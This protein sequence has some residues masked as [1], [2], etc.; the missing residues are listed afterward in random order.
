MPGIKIWSIPENRDV[1]VSVR[2]GVVSSLSDDVLLE[3]EDNACPCRLLLHK[4]FCVHNG[5]LHGRG[6]SFD[7]VGV[8][9]EADMCSV[10]QDDPLL[11][12]V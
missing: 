6:T 12:R 7:S 10:L 9:R 5:H 4:S 2:A 1:I 8:V 3:S 11:Q